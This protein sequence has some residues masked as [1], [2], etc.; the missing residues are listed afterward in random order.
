MG[1]LKFDSED[2]DTLDRSVQPVYSRLQGSDMNNKVNS[3]MDHVWDGFYTGQTRLT[4][5][6]ILVYLPQGA[7][8]DIVYTGTPPKKMKYTLTSQDPTVEM[9]VRI[10]YPS[11][12][13]R[14]VL[15]DGIRVDMNQWD[16]SI[17]MYGEVTGKY[18]GENRYIGV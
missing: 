13:S 2:S 4:R 15:K 16:E 1:I 8:Y 17:R 14:Q 12:E 9:V 5:F 11:A 18:C 6:P 10:A 3:F 7:I